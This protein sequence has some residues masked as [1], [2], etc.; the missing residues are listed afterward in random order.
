MSYISFIQGPDS[1]SGKT[2]TWFVAAATFTLG[3]VSWYGP[4]RKYCYFPATHPTVLDHGC[5]T[6]IADVCQSSTIA[7]KGA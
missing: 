4:W 1:D 7:H 3:M 6:E 2:R 5:L